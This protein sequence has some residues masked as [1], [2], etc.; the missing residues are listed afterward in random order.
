[1]SQRV[2]CMV[3]TWTC[4]LAACHGHGITATRVD[5]GVGVVASYD[6]DGTPVSLSEVRL[7]APDATDKPVLLA[8]TDRNGCFMFRPDTSGVW[9]VT[10]DDGM[11]HV[12]TEELRFD[13][14]VVAPERNTGRMPKRYGVLA[15]LAL[16]FGIFGWSAFLRL[17]RTLRAKE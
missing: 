16:I 12:V 6:D 1:M 5:G 9:R 15:G 11:G 7:F 4:M 8:A 14:H 13:G 2:A 3:L 10:V 17:N